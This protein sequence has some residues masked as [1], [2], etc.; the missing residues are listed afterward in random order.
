MVF[1][2][3]FELKGINL[4]LLTGIGGCDGFS[5]LR[6]FIATRVFNGVSRAFEFVKNVGVDIFLDS[7]LYVSE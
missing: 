2:V 7:G 1:D 5:G 4:L 3:K 6:V